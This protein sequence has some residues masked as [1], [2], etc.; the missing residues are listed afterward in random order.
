MSKNQLMVVANNEQK[1]TNTK[2]TTRKRMRNTRF[3]EL[4]KMKQTTIKRFVAQELEK[5]GYKVFVRDGFVLGA[6]T[7]KVTHFVNVMLCAHMDTV[8]KQQP[9]KFIYSSVTGRVSS[10]QGIGGDDRCG[11]YMILDIIKTHQPY[12][13]FTEDEE[14]GCVGADKFCKTQFAEAMK[15]K[16]D[17]IIELDRRGYNDVVFYDCDNPEFTTF[18]TEDNLFVKQWGSCSDISYIAPELETAACNCSCGYFDEHKLIESVDLDQMNTNIINIKKILDKPVEKRF[19]YIEKVYSYYNWKKKGYGGYSGCY[20]YDY[21]DDYYD[22]YY[23]GRYPGSYKNYG[24]IYGK[25]YDTVDKDNVVDSQDS[26]GTVESEYDETFIEVMYLDE[27]YETQTEY[28]PCKSEGDGLLQF[29]LTHGDV[30]Y[31][32]VLDYNVY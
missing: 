23:Y 32:N 2:S 17:Y 4:C 3:E 31:N 5:H 28:L 13:L 29:F 22:D 10:P 25:E 15:G 8:H 26:N 1:E 11:I 12:V 9:R 20:G 27:N 14:I 7:E 18:M 30:C 19:E 16:L 6:P 21:Y 24:K